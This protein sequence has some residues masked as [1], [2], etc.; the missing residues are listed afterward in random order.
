MAASVAADDARLAR[1]SACESQWIESLS[2]SSV[3]RPSHLLLL[4]L[5]TRR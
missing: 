3:H 1:V 2:L 5:S 4:L